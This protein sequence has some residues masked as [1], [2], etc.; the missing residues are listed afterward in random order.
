MKSIRYILAGILCI[1]LLASCEPENLVPSG[2]AEEGLTGGEGWLYLDFASRPNDVVSTKFTLGQEENNIYNIFVFAFGPN[3]HKIYSKWLRPV[4]LLANESAVL[5]SESD[6]W[7]VSNSTDPNVMGKGGIKIKFSAGVGLKVYMI[8]NLDADMVKVSSDLLSH[9]VNSEEDLENFKLYMNVESVNRNGLFPMV[10]SLKDIT[11]AEGGSNTIN[12]LNT[13]AKP[14]YFERIDSKVRFVF[15]KGTRPDVNGQT[16]VSFTPKQWKVV[17]IPNTSYL[18]KREN[19][20]ACMVPAS[21]PTSSYSQ[22]ASNFFDSEWKN[23]EDV[24][25]TSSGFS[26]YMME[27]RQTPKRSD[28]ASY[29]DRSRQ[30]KTATGLNDKVQVQY[31]NYLGKDVTK[32]MLLFE[33]ANDFSTYVLVTGRVDMNLTGDHAGQVLG[34]EVQYLIHLGD[35]NYTG[36]SQWDTDVYGG[37]DN[38]RTERNTYYTY[39][40]TV[41]SVHNIRV[42]VET[43]K[44]PGGSIENQPGASGEVV[45]AKESIALCDAHYVS[46]TM[47]FHAANFY[48][49]GA[50][51]SYSSTIDNLTW[52]V[53]TPF[54]PEGAVPEK[55][56][57]VDVADHIDYK[58]VH[59]R[60]N[61]Q[62]GNGAY[63]SEKRRAYV[64]TTFATS[65]TI[66]NN[67][68]P[69]GTAGLRG[70]HND[71]V[72]DIIYLV[73]FIK[74]QVHLHVN[75]L[76]A[77]RS[78]PGAVDRSAFDKGVTA[79]G[80]FNVDS[81]KISMTV[82]VDEFY[83]DEDPISHAKSR[84][85]W[86]RFVNQP[87]RTMHILC[88]SQSSTDQESTATGSVITIQQKS[89]K[90]IYNVDQD[91]TSLETA[92][93][94][95]SDDES[96]GV[97]S[98]YNVNKD[99]WK[100]SGSNT[101]RFNG[102]ANSAFE[103]GVAPSGVTVSTI[104]DVMPNVRW[105]TYMDFEVENDTPQMASDH[106]SLRY[107]CMARNRDNNGDGVISKD[108]LRWY[109]ASSMQLVGMV[110]GHNLLEQSAKLY[111]RSA[112]DKVVGGEYRQMVASSTDHA[113][114][115]GPIV[116]WAQE[117]LSTSSYGQ[118]RQWER[119][120]T[121]TVRCV[122]N[123]GID[124]DA[125]LSELPQ[126]YVEI[127]TLTT[128]GQEYYS[129]E[130]TNLDK[131]A[132][133]D[134][135]SRELSY[136]SEDSPAN[137]LYKKFET[138]PERIWPKNAAG[139]NIS[140]TT[141]KM[142]DDITKATNG[143]SVDAGYCPEG[144]R[145][146]NQV[147]LAMMALN[148]GLG[149]DSNQNAPCR[150]YW[151]LGIKGLNIIKDGKNRECFT[152]EYNKKNITADATLRTSSARCVRD[153]RVE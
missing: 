11:I 79:D 44:D 31:V 114:N 28:F 117:G 89:I 34:A 47:T 53:K 132:L 50:D 76:N 126:N 124:E 153:V 67:T 19:E 142:N 30:V 81:A 48:T 17:N 103:W 83:Y 99:N 72:M 85:L 41:N 3:G 14:V 150:T 36:G 84:T 24:S 33:N 88:D 140:V 87:D 23:F 104:D 125:P 52:K 108:E 106:S 22:Y 119:D 63:Y 112:E 82:F 131:A 93:G 135:T 123:L 147:E 26:F 141:A 21:V 97:V 109:T 80:S 110:V 116:I 128:G 25:T 64:P 57:G 127:Q 118:A 15:K 8:T 75:Y 10:A 102:R 61:A 35:W 100:D 65:E 71:G 129:F 59:F 2:G 91:Y 151:S 145:L 95:E 43:S 51:G 1:G 69:D 7:W 149:L 13:A 138:S 45:I 38:F 62:D 60:L 107:Y 111:N 113:S 39:T 115:D 86:K 68:D 98:Y 40:V 20:D 56:N 70:Y 73:S 32:Q 54:N 139:E 137:L 122:R 16:I 136:L 49:K 6:S 78:D 5:K 146:P 66:R 9:S 58:W 101:D 94:I 90:T 74:E 18:L 46:K 42:E 37:I 12:R 96:S 148:G 55:I 92:W 144:Y 134:Y 4:D 105:R 143:S 77:L 120:V 133:R 27:N 130:C 152:M 29:N 121:Y